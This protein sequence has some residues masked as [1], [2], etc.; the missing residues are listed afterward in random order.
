MATSDDTASACTSD[1]SAHVYAH[2]IFSGL[3]YK[4]TKDAN[5]SLQISNMNSEGTSNENANSTRLA[6]QVLSVMDHQHTL[7]V[8]WDFILLF[9]VHT[10]K[11]NLSFPQNFPSF[12]LQVNF[13]QAHDTVT[14][15][16]FYIVALNKHLLHSKHHLNT[17]SSLVQHR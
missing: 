15:P 8:F 9:C 12:Y 10:K 11:D 6:V 2:R 1:S 4:H 17:A 16:P 5:R 7:A 3:I 14:S 13:C